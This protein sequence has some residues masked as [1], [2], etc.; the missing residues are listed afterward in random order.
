M[1]GPGT[2]AVLRLIKGVANMD[3]PT[4]VGCNEPIKFEAPQTQNARRR[5]GLPV[6]TCQVIANLYVDG[7]WDR[8]EHWHE[9]C[10]ED[11]GRPVQ[12]YH[13][14]DIQWQ[15]NEFTKGEQR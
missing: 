4:C 5:R 15:R 1:S 13:T 7:V 2:R 10:F 9:G 14:D 6:H 11:A 3:W 12:P 8:V